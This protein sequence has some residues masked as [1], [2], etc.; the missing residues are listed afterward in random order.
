MKKS[1]LIA[2]LLIIAL[3]VCSCAKKPSKAPQTDET[4]NDSQ[5]T[6]EVVYVNNLTGEPTNNEQ[7]KTLRPVAVAINN[8]GVAKTVQTGWND[9]D[10]IYET[11]IE[12]G[13]TRLL[14]IFKDIS[15][16]GEIGTIRSAR[17]Y[18][19]DIA[20]GHD[21][22]YVHAGADELHA[23]PHFK[24]NGLD[25]VNL[26]YGN[27]YGYANRQK[28][29]L[30]LEHTL[31]SSG[32]SLSKL[33]KDFSIRTQLKDTHT[34]NWQNFNKTAQKLPGGNC[35]NLSVAFS[36]FSV[37]KFKYDATT[38]TYTKQDLTDY[39][40]KQPLSVKNV[41]VLFDDVGL[42][43]NNI[44]VTLGL[45]GGEGYY[46]SNGTFQKINWTKGATFDTIKLTD[47]NG[48]ALAYNPGKSY[49]C[50]TNKTLKSKLVIG[51]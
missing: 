1:R 39:K 11:Y 12:G 46:F 19:G 41:V 22:F 35:T 21:A 33:I 44:H 34:A 7:L 47:E 16:A 28:N 48:N 24:A 18:F 26:L 17:Y 30:A 15:K 37:T 31:Y 4:P 8:E 5:Q 3:L 10:I 43:S 20:S 29:G 38:D 13:S 23:T 6:Q 25:N 42:K 50:I 36:G 45:K 14:A 27:Y 9:A 2:V 49:V 51:E 32:E 40:T